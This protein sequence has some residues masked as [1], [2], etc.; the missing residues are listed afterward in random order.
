MNI[1]RVTFVLSGIAFLAAGAS[2][3]AAQAPL[4]GVQPAVANNTNIA[5]YGMAGCGLGSMLFG[6]QTGIIQVLAATT[7]GVLGSQTFGISSG[8][9][10]CTDMG[11]GPATSKVF[12][13]T[14]R[15]AVAKD[16]SRGRGETISSLST[17]AGCA[18]STRVGAILQADFAKIFPSASVK[19]S[20][21]GDNVLRVLR[22][23][24]E[25]SCKKLG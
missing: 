4:A 20:Q 16:I 19:S 13:E 9:S 7:N 6:K 21:V 24:P 10:N 14:N 11:G 3:A 23:H 8:T 5:G 15:E 25:L 18:D 17:L 22:E 2:P 1:R 12:I